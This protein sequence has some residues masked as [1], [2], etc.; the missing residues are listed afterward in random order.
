MLQHDRLSTASNATWHDGFRLCLISH[1][2]A[3]PFSLWG[4]YRF[5]SLLPFRP[6]AS[7]GE[8]RALTWNSPHAFLAAG[9][10][11][12]SDH[13]LLLCSLLLGFGLDAFV[14]CGLAHPDASSSSSSEAQAVERGLSG[15]RGEGSTGRE[16]ET[17]HMVREQSIIADQSKTI[18]GP[19]SLAARYRGLVLRAAWMLFR[20]MLPGAG[21]VE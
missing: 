7:V 5:V 19:E 2:T 12:V 17:G 1:R 6:R 14:C 13:A 4:Q 10:G 11:G 16:E 9:T 15:H 21:C 18:S 8:Q 20:T 3:H